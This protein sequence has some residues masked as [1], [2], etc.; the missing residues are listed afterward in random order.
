MLGFLFK[1]SRDAQK[2]FFCYAGCRRKIRQARRPFRNRSGLVKHHD[3]R[4][5]ELFQRFACLEQNTV[6]CAE[7]VS[8]HDCNRRCESEC[9][10][11]GNHE[12]RDCPLQCKGEVP[13]SDNEPAEKYQRRNSDHCR[14]ENARNPVRNPR[15]RR[16]GSRRIRDHLDNFLECRIFADPRCPALKVTGR[17]D[18]CGTDRAALCFLHWNGFAGQRGFIDRA[19]SGEHHAVHRNRFAGPDDKDITRSNRIDPD[20]PLFAVHKKHRAFRSQLHETA[21]RIR[22]AAFRHRLK[23]LSDRDQRRDHRRR[24]KIKLLM[25]DL[26]D[27]G[28]GRTGTHHSDQP[29]QHKEA[30]AKRH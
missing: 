15:D 2:L 9:T 22:S 1:R 7:A 14:Y 18:G 23:H 27:F 13:M 11:T 8:D 17:V 29:V 4:L 3:L 19:C 30:P 20:L 21:K 28:A 10:G 16:L 6:L 5:A 12:N 26:H 25:I 24:L